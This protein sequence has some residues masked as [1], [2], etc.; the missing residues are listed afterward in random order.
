MRRFN[1][2]RRSKYNA[3]RSAS[4]L[5]ALAG[6]S[7]ASQL[8]RRRAEELT[9]LVQAGQISNLEF[10]PT[11]KLTVAE[12]GYRPDFRYT[13]DSGEVVY[14]EAKGFETSDWLIRKK[15]WRVYGPGR[16]LI[17]VGGPFGCRVK[18]TITP[19]F[20]PSLCGSDIACPLAGNVNESSATKTTHGDGSV[21]RKV[22]NWDIE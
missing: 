20:G 2:S 13:T 17:V 5:P 16:L 12:I 21:S 22:Q 7:F 4:V 8:E 3:Q 11:V 1:P 15:L 14:E 18:E 6:R 10:Q 9:M 19:Q